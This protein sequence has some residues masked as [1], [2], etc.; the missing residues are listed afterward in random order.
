MG[1]ACSMYDEDHKSIHYLFGKPEGNRSAGSP[2]RRSEDDIKMHIKETIDD[3]NGI[4]L[5]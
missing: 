5:I 3:V 4:Y 2:K 1:W